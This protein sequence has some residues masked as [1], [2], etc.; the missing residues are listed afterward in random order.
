MNTVSQKD[1]VWA[2]KNSTMS[3]YFYAI[4]IRQYRVWK[5]HGIISPFLILFGGAFPWLRPRKYLTDIC[6]V[7]TVHAFQPSDK[8]I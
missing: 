2:V 7:Y 4:A 8:I 6:V 3:P 1:I 5:T